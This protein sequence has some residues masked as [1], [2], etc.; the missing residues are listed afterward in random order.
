[1]QNQRTSIS[2]QEIDAVINSRGTLDFSSPPKV[3]TMKVID[4]PI[5]ISDGGNRNHGVYLPALIF[6]NCIFNNTVSVGIYTFAGKVSFR[7]CEFNGNVNINSFGSNGNVDF[8]EDCIFNSDVTLHLKCNTDY[9]FPNLIFLSNLIVTGDC[10]GRL[11]ITS[12]NSLEDKMGKSLTFSGS[13]HDLHIEKLKIDRIIFSYSAKVNADILLSGNSINVLEIR[14][15]NLDLPFQIKGCEINEILFIGIKGSK[16]SI[17]ISDNSFIKNFD[18]SLDRLKRLDIS[19]SRVGSLLLRDVNGK[20]NIVMVEKSV[21]EKLQFREVYN[22]G[23]ISLRE[24]DIPNK[25][26]LSI[27]SSSLGK[28]DFINCNFSKASFE[29]EN[30]KVTELFLS[31]TDFPKIVITNGVKN[32]SQAQL[33]FGQLNTSFQ[34]QGDTIRSLEYQSR[35]VEAHYNNLSKW[36]HGRFPF[37]DLTKINLWLNKW[38]NNFGRYW[39]RG[40][41]FS[42]I[43]GGIFFYCLVISTQEYR[44]A[45]AF[46]YNS[47]FLQSFLKFMNPLR[48]FE[49]E[50]LFKNPEGQSSVTLSW[51][52]YLCDFLG[53]V[54][55]AYGFYQ[56]IQAFRRFGRK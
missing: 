44:I 50:N 12:L 4:T 5:S 52:S 25:G 40:I 54:F 43:V 11:S 24:L 19:G 38:S 35:E 10:P 45:F 56:T 14:N 15:I 1:M 42:F 8:S 16:E 9:N 7:D 33:A 30:S 41:L 36:F 13:C 21:I 55:V 29:F 23:L 22:Y 47:S 39:A 3:V 32:N 20:D 37:V 53:R 18:L 2:K 49:L 17:V 48:F 6:A 28:T 26:I 34:K 31:E 46:D 51:V 27:V